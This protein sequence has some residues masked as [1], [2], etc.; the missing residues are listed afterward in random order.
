MNCE[1]VLNNFL[2][3][4]YLNMHAESTY[5]KIYHNKCASYNRQY[6]KYCDSFTPMSKQ[7]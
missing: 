3:C 1:L 4:M 2:K 7:N 6:L 5:T